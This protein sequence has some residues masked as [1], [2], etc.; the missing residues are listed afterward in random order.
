MKRVLLGLA[1]DASKLEGGLWKNYFSLL[2][3][4]FCSATTE[5]LRKTED[6]CLFMDVAAKS[7]QCFAF[8]CLS[9]WWQQCF[10]VRAG[11]QS[12]PLCAHRHGL[13]QD[14][15]VK[16]SP[17]TGLRCRHQELSVAWIK[18]WT[19]RLL[20][21]LVQDMDVAK[22]PCWPRFESTYSVTQKTVV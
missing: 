15:D 20:R 13:D 8:Q 14:G 18:M 10:H 5:A 2:R 4:F 3:P 17:W 11:A 9:S 6:N 12:G 19:S 1:S 16:T 22:V 7:L 21:G